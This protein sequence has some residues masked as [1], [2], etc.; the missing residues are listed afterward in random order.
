MLRKKVSGVLGVRG[1]RSS[2]PSVGP[3]KREKTMSETG[4]QG[5]ES[6]VHLKWGPM[7][8]RVFTPPYIFQAR[9]GPAGD[10]ITRGRRKSY[11]P[12]GAAR[13][14]YIRDER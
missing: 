6:D 1:A 3:R 13:K 4:D 2:W 14:K 7:L 11:K 12:M 5:A 9:S 8:L 10:I